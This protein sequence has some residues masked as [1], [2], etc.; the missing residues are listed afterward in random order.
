MSQKNCFQY[1]EGGMGVCLSMIWTDPNRTIWSAVWGFQSSNNGLMA[2]APNRPIWYNASN[3]PI[4]V[5]ASNRLVGNCR[6]G[7][8]A[9]ASRRRLIGGGQLILSQNHWQIVNV[10]SKKHTIYHRVFTY[11]TL[12]FKASYLLC[13]FCR[14][15]VSGWRHEVFKQISTY[16]FSSNL[17][18]LSCWR[19]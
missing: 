11:T 7:Q 5:T 6:G 19:E 18:I 10:W 14:C 3:H 8:S 16:P 17:I 13:I 12:A 2:A 15:R 9:L 4:R 1:F